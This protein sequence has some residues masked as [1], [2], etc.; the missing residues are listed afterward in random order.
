MMEIT[1]EGPF[2]VVEKSEVELH[3]D[4][5]GWSLVGLYQEQVIEVRID[6]EPDPHGTYACATMA[7]ERHHPATK[8]FFV[9]RQTV[10]D[11][12]AL[13][14]AGLNLAKTAKEQ[15]EAKART[16]EIERGKAER[17]KS[18]TAR[19]LAREER[20]NERLSEQNNSLNERLRKLEGD[21]GKVRT[22]IGDRAWKEILAPAEGATA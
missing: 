11:A 10:D 14:V 7:V 12:L 5:L 4:L 2:K 20:S 19:S 1:G 21:L 18:E 17:Q 3:S 8:T 15:A 13:A 9:L 16:A 22:S 6:Q